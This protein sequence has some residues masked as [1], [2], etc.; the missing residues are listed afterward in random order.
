MGT[1][2]FGEMRTSAGLGWMWT[3]T[4]KSVVKSRGGRV[5]AT[6]ALESVTRITRHDWPA[7]WITSPARSRK[8]LSFMGRLLRR[9]QPGLCAIGEAPGP[10]G[11]GALGGGA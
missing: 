1:S 8:G 3:R 9:E 2:E 11:L 6:T 7:N 4:P 10:V 5:T